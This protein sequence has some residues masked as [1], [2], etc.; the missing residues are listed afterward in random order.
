MTCIMAPVTSIFAKIQDT[1]RWRMPS[2]SEPWPSLFLKITEEPNRKTR[3][4]NNRKDTP[5]PT[6]VVHLKYCNDTAQTGSI[7]YTCRSIPSS[8]G[9]HKLHQGDTNRGPQAMMKMG[10]RSRVHAASSGMKTVT[11]ASEVLPGSREE[12]WQG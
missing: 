1:E 6:S 4:I 3:W 5:F 7:C 2:K 10:P 12:D 11:E 8:A 9:G